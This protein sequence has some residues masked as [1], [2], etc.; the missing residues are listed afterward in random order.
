MV[1]SRLETGWHTVMALTALVFVNEE[2]NSM[3]MS[4]FAATEEEFVAFWGKHFSSVLA[5]F[6]ESKLL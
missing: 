3:L 6:T 5:Y 4:V 1:M 2:S